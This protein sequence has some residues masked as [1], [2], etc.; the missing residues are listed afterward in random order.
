VSQEHI[1]IC[2]ECAT[3]EACDAAGQCLKPFGPL[4]IM[5]HLTPMERTMVTARREAIQAGVLILLAGLAD[6]VARM[7]GGETIDDRALILIIVG[8]VVKALMAVVLKWDRANQ[9]A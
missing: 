8:V 3:P 4:V 2:D 1:K 7:V 6:I 5:P 9:E